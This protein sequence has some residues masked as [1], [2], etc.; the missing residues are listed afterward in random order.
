M[1]H[2]R[3]DFYVVGDWSG[4]VLDTV[5]PVMTNAMLQP[6]LEEEE[7]EEQESK[8]R[9]DSTEQ[10]EERQGAVQSLSDRNE[11]TSATPLPSPM[12]DVP[13]TPMATPMAEVESPVQRPRPSPKLSP[14]LP[15]LIPEAQP[16]ADFQLP[17]SVTV[18]I[19]PEWA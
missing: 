11:I 15:T 18:R 7:E 3:G 2:Q 9:P 16:R 10:H 1:A 6:R 5:C 19:L 14:S 17:S 8:D 13:S 12:F 4:I